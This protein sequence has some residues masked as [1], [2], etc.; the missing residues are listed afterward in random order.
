[1][2]PTTIVIAIL[3]LT[4]QVF[5]QETNATLNAG[6]L[7]WQVPAGSFQGALSWPTDY[8]VYGS[9][10]V[11]SFWGIVLACEGFQ[12][13]I[14]YKVAQA[15]YHL[16]YLNRNYFILTNE[17]G[18]RIQ[19]YMRYPLPERW[20]LDVNNRDRDYNAPVPRNLAVDP[21]L[22]SDQMVTSVCNSSIGL[23]VTQKAY[24]WTN[25]E[26]ED[27]IIVEYTFT[28]TGDYDDDP[29]TVNA[30]NQLQGVYIGLQSM[31]QVSGLGGLVVSSSGG[32]SEGN[33]D[34]V[35]YYGEEAGDSLRVLYSW[36]GDAEPTFASGNDE[37]NP[38]PGTGQPLS[39]Q[40]FGR[41]ILHVDKAVNDSTD[42]PN[43]PVTTHYGHWANPSSQLS[44]ALTGSAEAIYNG[45]SASTHI[46]APLD[47]S[48][49][50]YTGDTYATTEFLKTST[51][52][53][54]PYDFT[55][56]GQSIRIVTCLAVG[57]ISF[58][59]AMELGTEYEPGSE[60]YLQVVRSGRDSLFATISK[61]RRAFYDS[62]TVSYDF[63]IAKGSAI[64][65]NIKDPLPPP[66][67]HYYSDSAHVRV[68]WDDVSQ[69]LDPD[70]GEPDWVG[71]R[72]YRRAMS[73]FD[74]LH[75]VASPF[76]EV[77]NTTDL[78]TNYDDYDV[79][80]GRCYWYYVVAYDW[81]GLESNRFLNR[82]A[83]GTRAGQ[84]TREGGCALRP[85]ATSLDS[86]VVVPNPY[87]VH[88]VRLNRE[89]YN[90][91]AFF[92][93]P[94]KCR[95]RI[96]TQTGDLLYTYD[97][98]SESNVVEWDQISDAQQHI[99]SGL[100]IYVVDQA[101]DLSG[102]DLGKAMGKFVVIR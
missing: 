45:L 51:M 40:Y 4:G 66:S 100:Y 42:E 39:P 18:N 91:L 36:D 12:D 73:V 23:T 94:Y 86:I 97:K 92:N 37:G 20:V 63:T 52:A 75:P 83:P 1:M 69:E 17:S 22:P 57:G 85:Q 10:N 99:V 70:T 41:A 27:F 26:Y 77:Y 90:V 58:E 102:N 6:N 98:E 74:I 101:Q 48:T 87:H 96:Y 8:N 56:L 13:T 9:T 46:D 71:Y 72:V 95:L 38:L 34:W 16:D 44:L 5:G 79:G 82:T 67:V 49:G 2:K 3:L 89:V 14:D 47:W 84:E 33:D 78:V 25:P 55:E 50:Q 21:D 24:A 62:Q 64:D 93:L 43:Q 31:S 59:R 81:D 30:D 76:I 19:H 54:G 88:A 53:F 28:N 11:I 15:L 61:A 68:T 80:L 7:H 65:R 35:D 60:E 29:A 32:I